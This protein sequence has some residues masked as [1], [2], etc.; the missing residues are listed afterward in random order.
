M[1][2]DPSD[3]VFLQNPYPT[4]ARLREQSPVLKQDGLTWF[5]N[6]ADVNVVLRSSDFGRISPQTD[7]PEWKPFT[8]LNTNSFF[9]MEPPDH[10]RIKNLVHKAFTPRR[11]RSLSDTIRHIATTL[12]DGLH[13]EIELFEDFAIPLPLAVIGELLGVPEADRRR[14]RPWSQAIVGMFEL[15]RDAETVARAVRA[16]AEFTDYLD[17]LRLLRLQEPQ[18]DLITALAFAEHDSQKLTPN[19]LIATCVLLL[20]AGHEATVNVLGNGLLAL[21]RHPAQLALLRQRLDLISSAVEELLRFDTPLQLF[22]RTALRPTAINGVTLM[23]GDEVAV[24][25]GAANR[26]PQVFHSPDTLDIKRKPNPHVAFGAGIHYC[27]GAPLARLELT[28]ALETLLQRFSVIQLAG[29]WNFGRISSFAASTPS[30][31]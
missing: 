27:I 10:T 26:D 31:Y 19:E 2:F 6:H 21:L 24:L 29:R 13:G 11:I 14:L 25:L 18:N 3:P 16:S 9:D 7:P 30:I 4:F 28:I 8:D 12:L 20:N 17:H 22:R 15:E 23:T 1:L 5:L